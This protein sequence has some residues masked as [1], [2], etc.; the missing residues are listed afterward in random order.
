[1]HPTAVSMSAP[2]KPLPQRNSRLVRLLSDLAL[3]DDSW[4][5]REFADRLG[6]M[7]NFSDSILLADAHKLDPNKGFEKNTLDGEDLKSSVLQTKRSLVNNLIKSCSPGGPAGRIPWP[8]F[9]DQADSGTEL[10]YDPL[11]RFYLAHQREQDLAIR[12]ARS[13]ARD[14]LSSCSPGL[15]K[16]ATLDSVFE[17][18]LMEPTRRFFAL[19]PQLLERRF[20]Q[21]QQQQQP[22]WLNQFR[23]EVQALL[24]AELDLRLQPLLGLVE[25]LEREVVAHP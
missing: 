11:Q 10:S 20:A 15:R 6:Q 16:L 2:S 22:Q 3:I 9:Y 17:D 13:A 21:L 14:A 18:T 19:V 1:M 25:A 7:L 5:Q 4:P 24:L 23:K 8:K 12:V